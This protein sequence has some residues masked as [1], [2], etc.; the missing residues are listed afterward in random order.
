MAVAD[1]VL[2]A[3]ADFVELDEKVV[4]VEE[5]GDAVLLMVGRGARE[6]VVEMEGDG[7]PRRVIL[8]EEVPVGVWLLRELTEV[9]AE[10]VVVR[11]RGGERVALKDCS[12]GE[13]LLALQRVGVGDADCVLDSLVDA[14]TD[15]VRRILAVVEA[16]PVGVL[17]AI[18]VRV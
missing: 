8:T 1:P 5:E 6:S 18:A 17:E 12:R 15:L 13:A 4:A 10:M 9:V 14:L 16:E 3:E 2:E 11:V 7:E